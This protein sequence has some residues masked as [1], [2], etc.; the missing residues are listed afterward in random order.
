MTVMDSHGKPGIF[1]ELLIC[2]DSFKGTFS[3][4]EVGEAV[5]RG[6]ARADTPAIVMPAGDGGEG[7]L[8]ALIEPLA[9]KLASASVSDP[10]GRPVEAQYGISEQGIAVVEMA[11]ASGLGL[12]APAERDAINASTRGTGELIIDAIEH[13]ASRILLTVGGSATSD[14]GSGALE[15]LGEL[16][17]K[18]VRQV[19][20]TVVCDVRTPF[21]QAAAVFGP[22]KGATPE[23]VT[24]L[25]ARLNAQAA[26]YDR[27]PR[28][29]AMTGAAGGLA[30]AMWAQYHAELVAGAAFVLNEIGYDQRMRQA[31]SVITGEGRLDR[32]SL[33]G[34][35]ISEVATRARQAGGPCH[36][37]VGSNQLDE[38]DTRILD[39]QLVVESTTIAELEGAGEQIATAI[40]ADRAR[41]R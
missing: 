31:L 14:G 9:L 25:T 7:T 39:L 16:D 30:G 28:G 35:L 40:Q 19:R 4:R 13:G 1:E 12:V 29:V 6:A 15:V 8:D 20:F 23:Q 26:G 3:S 21:E 33:M 41:G 22:Q 18:R 5:A 24:E 27:D 36:A 34:K 11:A 2:S 32:Q 10:L 37:V 17:P 38:F